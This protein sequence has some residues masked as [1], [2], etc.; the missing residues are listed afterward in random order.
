MSEASILTFLLLILIAAVGGSATAHIRQQKQIR[1]QAQ[2][3]FLLRTGKHHLEIARASA[4]QLDASELVRALAAIAEQS[5]RRVA[6]LA[7]DDTTTRDLIQT[8]NQLANNPRLDPPDIAD[9]AA[10][11]QTQ[12]LLF[13]ASQ[14]LRSCTQNAEVDS[15]SFR[16]ISGDIIWRQLEL[17][18]TFTSKQADPALAKGD[19]KYALSLYK[20]ALSTLKNNAIK[21]SRKDALADKLKQQIEYCAANKQVS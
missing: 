5:F 2:I 3:N 1:T 15:A 4:Q 14:T 7:N 21:D 11:E 16:R 8:A 9:R 10:L 12:R 20:Q 19:T 6:Q 13:E 17:N 18:V